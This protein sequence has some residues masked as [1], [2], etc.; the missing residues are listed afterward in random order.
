MADLGEAERA[1]QILDEL[2]DMGRK[3][4]EVKG[5]NDA[6]RGNMAK[7]LVQMAE[8]RS[9]ISRD[10]KESIKLKREALALVGVGAGLGV[11]GSA[12]ALVGGW[13]S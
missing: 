7:I 3:R 6:S 13:R 4:L 1:S 2:Y 9:Q 8:L 10:L 11:V 12:S 5:R